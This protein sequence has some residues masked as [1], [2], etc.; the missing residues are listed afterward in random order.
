MPQH[1][2]AVA[3]TAA[4]ALVLLSGCDTLSFSEL[5][6]DNIEAVKITRITVRPGSGDVTVRGSGAATDVRI[7]RK[8]R[9]QGTQPDTGY[10]ITGDE[11]V[12]DTGCGN[13]CS[14]S[15]EVTAPEGVTVRGETGSGDITLSQVGAVD[16]K[17][18]SGDVSVTAAHG[19]VSA[20]TGSGD[21]TVDDATG[22]VRL[23]TSSGD[24]E[25]RR[26]AAGVDAETSSGDVTVELDQP[27]SAR[28]H[29][30]S[31]NVELAVPDGRYRVRTSTGSGETSLAVTDDPTAALL[32]DISTGSG[33]LT[34]S[35]R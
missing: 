8:V 29:T 18:G 6:Y 5:T 25:A 11:L 27:A 16:V 22:A 13:R 20:E 21:I 7:K 32:L 24:V 4:A 1:R 34:I 12:L 14:V 35:R 15:W 26:L 19:D 31:G 3:A 23:H 9:Y 2:T 17:L 10:R 30:G 28:V 33:D